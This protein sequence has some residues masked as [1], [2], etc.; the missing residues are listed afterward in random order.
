M[1]KLIGTKG[2]IAFIIVILFS[3]GVLTIKVT[4]ERTVPVSTSKCEIPTCTNKAIEGS[5]YCEYHENFYSNN[6]NLN[7]ECEMPAC[8]NKAMEG[9][10]YCEYHESLYSDDSNVNDGEND[11]YS[12]YQNNT[13]SVENTPKETETTKSSSGNGNGYSA[14]ENKKSYNRS[15]VKSKKTYENSYDDGYEAIYYDE[16]YDWDRYQRDSDYA[17]GVDDAMEDDGEGW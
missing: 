11:Y 16:D 2:I 12:Q 7:A 1:K 4:N 10:D 5:D 3:L 14:S 8:T 17:N 15:S 9:G 13:N 6:A